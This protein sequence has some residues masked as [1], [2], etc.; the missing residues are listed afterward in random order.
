MKWAMSRPEADSRSTASSD[1][2]RVVVDQR[3]GGV[4]H[5]LGVGHAHDLEHVVELDLRPAVGDELLERAE[6][7][8]EA[9][10]RVARDQADRG[11]GHLDPLLLG[12]PPQHARDLLERRAVEVEA[13]AAVDDRG[14]HLVRLGR[15]EHEDDVRRRLLER[16][17]ERVPG[18]VREHVRLVED[19]DAAAAAHRRER[20]VLAQL[21]D[22]V[23][24][25]VRRGVHLDD[26]ERGAA[27]GSRR[28]PG[29]RAR[30]RPSARPRRSARRRAASPCSSCRCRASRRT[31]TRG[32]PCRARSRCAACGRCAPGRPPRR[33]CGGGGGGRA[34]ARRPS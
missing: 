22:V 9:A 7:V 20:D 32:G 15:G 12:H 26:V 14:R 8:A 19:V 24:R 18:R 16:L 21:A 13:V 34:R 29:R 4:E 1:R 33:R 10:G 27:G 28:T 30:S 2:L 23:D 3:L 31:G 11:V 5:E 6:R 17:Q 25:V